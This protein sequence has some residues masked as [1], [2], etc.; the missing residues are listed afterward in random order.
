[1]DPETVEFYTTHA[2]EMA[3]SYAVAQSGVESL[4]P[5]AFPKGIRVLDLGCGSGRDLNALLDIGYDAHGVDAS[6][7]MLRQAASHFPRLEGRLTH[8]HL[9]QLAKIPDQ[10]FQGVLCSAVLMHLPEELLF[11]TVF[12]LRRI[13]QPGGR[14]LLSTPL[15]GP[16]THPATRRDDKGRLFNGV[17]PENFQFLFEK[18]GFRQLNRWDTADHLGRPERRWATQLFVLETH[19]SEP[20][21]EST[22]QQQLTG[23]RGDIGTSSGRSHQRSWRYSPDRI[24]FT[25]AATSS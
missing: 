17:T 20:F 24:E 1:M 3:G 15:Q 19:G 12:N 13:L 23:K 21:V 18:I 2:P 10:S 4:F 5:V 6:P 25:A 14:L 8:D 7:E 22:L 11:D 9:P 16:A